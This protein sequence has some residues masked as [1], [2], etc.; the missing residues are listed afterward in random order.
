MENARWNVEGAKA[1]V[2]PEIEIK[3]AVGRG[4]MSAV[5]HEWTVEEEDPISRK[6]LYG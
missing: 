1:G 4:R 2:I 3:R 5:P 6:P